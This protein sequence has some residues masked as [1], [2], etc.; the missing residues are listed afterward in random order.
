MAKQL[1][2]KLRV[3]ADTDD[4]FDSAD[5]E[6]ILGWVNAHAKAVDYRKGHQK[7]YQTKKR[8]LAKYAAQLMDADELKRIG[9]LAEEE[10]ASG[11]EAEGE[12][13]QGQA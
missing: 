8:L 2:N 10:A 5:S 7:V 9:Q 3:F 6:T 1:E 13:G 11:G 12:E 4:L